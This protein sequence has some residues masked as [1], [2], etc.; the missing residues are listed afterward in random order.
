MKTK[1][2]DCEDGQVFSIGESREGLYIKKKKK[3]TF[4]QV[5][6]GE[7]CEDTRTNKHTSHRN[8]SCKALKWEQACDQ[9]IAK[10]QSEQGLRTHRKQKFGELCYSQII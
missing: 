8:N 9:R 6:R 5:R 7:P 4:W 2:A 10:R 3:V 1:I